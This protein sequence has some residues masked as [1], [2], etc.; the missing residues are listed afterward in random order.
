MGDAELAITPDE[1]QVFLND[2]QACLDHF[3]VPK[4]EQAELIRSSPVSFVASVADDLSKG[5]DAQGP[6]NL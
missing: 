1:W 3:G 4:P 5:P 2:F 6:V